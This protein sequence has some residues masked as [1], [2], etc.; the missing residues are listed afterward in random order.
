[1]LTEINLLLLLS[2]LLL[3]IFYRMLEGSET[4]RPS[5]PYSFADLEKLYTAKDQLP[6]Q[7]SGGL[8]A[9]SMLFSDVE[10]WLTRTPFELHGNDSAICDCS[11][12]SEQRLG[13]CSAWTLLRSDLMPTIFSSPDASASYA[14][15]GSLDKSI[16]ARLES[17]PS[18]GLLVDVSLVW[19]LISSMAVIDA[20]TDERNCGQISYPG[21]AN[22]KSVE[23]A[24]TPFDRGV[25]ADGRVTFHGPLGGSDLCK[26]DCDAYDDYCKL[27]NAGGTIAISKLGQSDTGN[28]GCSDCSGPFPKEGVTEKMRGCSQSSLPFACK[29]SRPEDEDPSS[30]VDAK[31]WA[32][33]AK[34]GGYALA[35]LGKQGE[36]LAKLFSGDD[37]AL[38]DAWKVGGSQCKFLKEDWKA[39]IRGMKLFYES[40]RKA[41]D[42]QRKHLRSQLEGALGR[43]YLMSCPGYGYNYFENEVNLY[44]NPS[45]KEER[46]RKLAEMQT[47]ILTKAVV[48]FYVVGATCEEQLASL[49][50]VPCQIRGA[51]F[52]G[53]RDRCLGY[54]SDGR[55]DDATLK[56]FRMLEKKHLEKGERL[57]KQLTDAFNAKYR[58]AGSK[59]RQAVALRYLGGNSTFFDLKHL[60]ALAS[61]GQIPLKDVFTF[62]SARP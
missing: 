36:G 54:F 18:I 17:T 40:V 19:P 61:E 62:I 37:G 4:A 20:A 9:H 15:Q 23:I 1:M 28:W 60:N 52:S 42:Q 6:A 39:W 48:G 5:A 50:G 41:W 11:A 47:K 16:E 8:L 58:A 13:S 44:F 10:K 25:G 35:L 24:C 51:A 43:N 56:K 32:P 46:F 31:A 45:S 7:V 38:A 53:A 2:L 12:S 33:Y 34:Q 30:I 59:Q 14:G 29:L 22:Q 57:V 26:R 49:E 3:L 21:E 55:S 27:Q